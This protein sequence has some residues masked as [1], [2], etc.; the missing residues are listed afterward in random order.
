MLFPKPLPLR[1]YGSAEFAEVEA[2]WWGGNRRPVT[3]LELPGCSSAWPERL[4]WEQEAVGSNPIT[5]IH[6]TA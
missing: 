1:F 2:K 4:L 6:I 5:P 3:T